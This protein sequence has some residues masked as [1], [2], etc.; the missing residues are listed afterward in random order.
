M[1]CHPNCVWIGLLIS[2]GCRASAPRTKSASS[3]P[4]GIVPRS[5]P[6]GADPL[7][8]EYSLAR[9][10]KFCGVTRAE[11]R[12]ASCLEFTRMCAAWISVNFD[13]SRWYWAR[14]R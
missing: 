2:P 7:S 14:S 10:A 13:R 1:M 3:W 12:S 6:F 5:P 11:M 4:T 9:S 8:I